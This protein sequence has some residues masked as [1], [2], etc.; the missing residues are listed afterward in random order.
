[1]DTHQVCYSAW[2]AVVDQ[3]SQ[4]HLPV[5]FTEVGHV[6][7]E[8]GLLASEETQLKEKTAFREAKLPVIF[9]VNHL[10]DE[11][12]QKLE[13]RSLRPRTL[14]ECLRPMKNFNDLSRQSKLVLLEVLLREVPLMDLGALEIFPFEDGNFRSLGAPPIFLHRDGFEKTLFTRQLDISIDA[15]ELSASASRLL[16]EEV[17]TGNQMVRYRT[18]EDLRS[19]FLD[20]IVMN[21]LSDTI[22]IDADRIPV[23]KQV[24][25]W[26]LRYYK[27]QL[28]L[29]AL[30]PLW[31][32]PLQGSAFRRLVPLDS[33]NF[34]TWFRPGE[35]NDL[36]HRVSA[37]VPKCALKILACDALSEEIL[38]F[39]LSFAHQEPSMLIKDGSEFESFLE[40]LVQD[41]SVVQT[42]PEE[43]KNSIMCV[44]RQLFWSRTQ[45]NQES[46]RNNFKSLYLFK[47]IQ[48]PENARDLS[49]TRYRTDVRQDID[50]IG[51]SSL[52]PV[53]SRPG[54]VLLDVSNEHDQ[55]LF[56]KM[57]LLRC[58]NAV[59]ILEDI[60]ISALGDGSYDG[61]NS[62]FRFDVATQLFQN[63]YN[64][65]E[66]AQ[67]CL[68]NLAV[69]PIEKRKDDGSL[70]FARPP[71]I[72][73]PDKL[74][75][76]NL[77]FEDEICLAE[78]KFYNRFSAVLTDCGMVQCLNERVV[79]DRIRSYG[80]K[81][82]GFGVVAPR[83]T[84]L[85]QMSFPEDSTQLAD[86]TRVVRES[87]WL[88]ARAPEKSDSLTSSF[89]CRDKSDEPLVGNV[90]H[91]LPFKIDPT[92]RSIL[93]WHDCVEVNVLI[94]Q[95][96]RSIAVRD[97]NSIDQTL[98]YI[99]QH[100]QVENY[101]GRLSELNFVYTTEGELVNAANVCRQGVEKLV[102]YLH[103]VERR[104]WD[105][106]TKIMKLVN[107]PEIP[108]LGQLKDVQKALESKNSLD[109]LDLNVA[110]ELARIWGIQFHEATDGLKLPNDK[111][112]FVEIGGLVFNDAPWLLRGSHDFVHNNISRTIAEQLKIQPLSELSMKGALGIVDLNEDEFYQ[113]EEI[114]DGIRDTLDRYTRE[115]T[116]HEYLANADDCG[117]A[118]EVNFFFD[119]TSYSTEH[120]V[121]KDLRGLQ[122]SS[123]LIHN[124]GGG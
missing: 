75:L 35:V 50:F 63:Y 93:G 58:M 25:T 13:S 43:V 10:L 106:H 32:V 34:V 69:V 64:I 100:H 54:R 87:K 28:P 62:S 111:G 12:R 45:A 30:G 96:I 7:L 68:S 65:S 2:R 101:A 3:I 6:A 36:S 23:V 47:A 42:A 120:L 27:D 123:L 26:I 21:G 116:F 22:L 104:F 76:R 97:I 124:N 90:W 41:R 110:T 98:S 74:A 59:Q 105:S 48:W 8:D 82:L 14:Y 72:L 52:V 86:F 112:A 9:L 95:L 77:Y 117:S 115:H 19:Y 81:E 121:T 78:Q 33:S 109:E 71:D 24:W 38:Q 88:P 79:L 67:K 108:K 53:P 99:C 107:V 83:A 37:L 70:D 122:G 114:A 20:H 57:S 80:R 55:A 103:V 40:F 17:R 16:H 89:E 4:N 56:K 46:V 119:E 1:L 31:L 73:N 94:S 113:R 39:L 61:M 5:W 18:P 84:K 118:T 49:V 60:V 29:Q 91:V 15:D 102:P 44:L 92:W 85:L 66:I 11:A 51:L